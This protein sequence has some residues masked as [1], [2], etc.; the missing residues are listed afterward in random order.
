MDSKSVRNMQ[1]SLPKQSWEIVHLVGFYYKNVSL[2]TALWMSS[3]MCAQQLYWGRV[4]RRA[5]CRAPLPISCS[6]VKNT[7]R[8]AFITKQWYHVQSRQVTTICSWH[9][10]TSDNKYLTFFPGKWQIVGV[11]RAVTSWPQ[12]YHICLHAQVS[13]LSTQSPKPTHFWYYLITVMYHRWFWISWI[14]IRVKV[15]VKLSHYR[16]RQALRASGGWGAQNF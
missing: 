1:S 16:P 10:E 7:A 11:G 8:I 15:K 5:S 12:Y 2:C 9:N 14:N 13:N 6:N 4:V 3:S